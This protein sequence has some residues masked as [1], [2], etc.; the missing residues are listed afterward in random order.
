MPFLLPPFMLSFCRQIDITI[1]KERMTPCRYPLKT[2]NAISDGGV[3][4]HSFIV[5][6]TFHRSLNLII[7]QKITN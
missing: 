7:F 4:N 3:V 5:F 1:K 2:G 6:L